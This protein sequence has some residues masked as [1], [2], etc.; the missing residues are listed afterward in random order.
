MVSRC[1][2]APRPIV[3]VCSVMR[4][5]ALLFGLLC[6]HAVIA[7]P[8]GEVDR[9]YVDEHRRNWDGNGPRPLETAIWYPAKAVDAA[10]AAQPNG[11]LFETPAV[12]RDAVLADTHDKYPLVLLSHGTGGCA[13]A[14]LWMGHYLASHG[15]VVAA[16]NHHGNTCAEAKP[17]P[18]GYLLWWER[19]QD[20]RVALDRVLADPLFG[21]RIDSRRIGALGFSLG[22]YT[23]ITVAGARID[24]ARYLR[25]CSSSAR[26]FTCGPQHEYPD[27]PELFEQL[28]KSDPVVQNA[29]KHSGDSYREPRVRA[30][31]A[32]AP[33][34]GSGFAAKDVADIHI[35]V[36]IVVGAADTVA[37]P[38][39]NA[40]RFATLIPG[41]RLVEIPGKVGHYDFV[42]SCTEE[43]KK[44][45][46]Q[47]SIERLC[48]DDPSVDRHAVQDEVRSLALEFFNRNLALEGAAR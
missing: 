27:A 48:Y 26:D 9:H 6:T 36:E 4:A 32:L 19:A 33:V 12:V 35:P 3:T 37:P 30:V 45:A 41:A 2:R 13:G 39:T 31:F 43:G 23:I 24:R 16:I 18:R 46:A 25:F 14:L 47:M 20:L 11:A 40:E 29:L 42:P 8:V 44:M 22:G 17:D 15:Y 1:D 38:A 7:E 21:T 10:A 28:E 5:A 34:F